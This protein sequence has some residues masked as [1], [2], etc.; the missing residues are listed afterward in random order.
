MVVNCCFPSFPQTRPQHFLGE[1]ILPVA[2]TPYVPGILGVSEVQRV[3]PLSE[4]L[5]VQQPERCPSGRT[6]PAGRFFW[7]KGVRAGP[8]GHEKAPP[9]LG[10]K[11]KQNQTG[12]FYG[13]EKAP[14]ALGTRVPKGR[15]RTLGVLTALDR[16]QEIG[17]CEIFFFVVA[18]HFWGKG[19]AC[20]TAEMVE[21]AASRQDP[22]TWV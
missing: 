15:R 12:P 16:G 10:T 13:H 3:D 17:P 22:F 2:H 20:L 19:T 5:G 11:R 21:A 6:I 14:Q 9:S 8:Y 18:C 1:R 7:R 4:A